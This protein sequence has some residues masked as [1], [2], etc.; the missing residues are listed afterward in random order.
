MYQGG[1]EI[2]KIILSSSERKK[3]LDEHSEAK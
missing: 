3:Y 1:D 2:Y